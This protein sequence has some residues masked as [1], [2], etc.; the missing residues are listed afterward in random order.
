MK[1]SVVISSFWTDDEKPN[2]L[3]KCLDSIK[4]ADEILSL[5][6]HKNS[7]LGY[8]DSWNRLAS[9][10]TGDYIIFIGDN[11]VMEY[12]NLKDLCIYNSVTSPLLNNISS[13]FYGSIFCM[14]REIYKK[15]GLYDMAF[16]L[17]CHYE[18]DDLLFRL[19]QNDIQTVSINSVNFYKIISGRTIA[20]IP[21]VEAKIKKNSEIFNLK[22][23]AH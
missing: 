7:P 19:K 2:I 12:G 10:A 20:N 21:D 8:S 15:I 22:W 18:D 4:G 6:T 5:V 3:K 16:N 13:D 14:P 9:L 23:G 1:I 11:C 17:G